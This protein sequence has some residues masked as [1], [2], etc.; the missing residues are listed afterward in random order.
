MLA[1]TPL[2]E[3]L[4]GRFAAFAMVVIIFLL[5]RSSQDASMHVLL[6]ELTVAAVVGAITVTL[7]GAESRPSILRLALASLASVLAYIGLSF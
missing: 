4:A 3:T 1:A 2:E 5:V 6:V 7:H